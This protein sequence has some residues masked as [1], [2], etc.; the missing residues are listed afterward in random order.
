M[1]GS[2]LARLLMSWSDGCGR[3]QSALVLCLENGTLLMDPNM[4]DG[5]DGGVAAAAEEH[6]QRLLGLEGLQILDADRLVD[7][8]DGH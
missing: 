7:L 8:G 1:G 3:R 6:L 2:R 5:A 4:Q